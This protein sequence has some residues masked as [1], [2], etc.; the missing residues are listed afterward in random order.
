MDKRTLGSTLL[1]VNFLS[2]KK[3]LNAPMGATWVNFYGNEA[4]G[5]IKYFNRR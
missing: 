3:I 4:S 2:V 5:V 1:G